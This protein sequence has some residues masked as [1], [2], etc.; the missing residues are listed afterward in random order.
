MTP[1]SQSPTLPNVSTGFQ[2]ER[3]QT[4][5]ITGDD[6]ELIFTKRPGDLYLEVRED[7]TVYTENSDGVRD[8]VGIP[9]YRHVRLPLWALREIRDYLAIAFP[10]LG[11]PQDYRGL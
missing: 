3:E 1:G 9:T 10:Q 4:T 5:K 11:N 2:P 8:P 7:T 6:L